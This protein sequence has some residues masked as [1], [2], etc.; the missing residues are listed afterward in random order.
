MGCD[1]SIRNGAELN[2]SVYWLQLCSILALSAI[3]PRASSQRELFCLVR[4]VC[5]YKGR[6]FVETGI[7]KI[8]EGFAVVPLQCRRIVLRDEEQHPHW[9]KIRVW[10]LP[11]G[12]LDRCDAERPY[13][14]LQVEKRKV[15][16]KNTCPA[17]QSVS[18]HSTHVEQRYCFF[19]QN[20][21]HTHTRTHIRLRCRPRT[22]FSPLTAIG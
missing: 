18:W 10:R 9:V 22:S 14:S 4:F 3:S 1:W 16:F 8:L 15:L 6:I 2:G 17:S 19:T 7:Y 12:Q 11:L 5:T 21:T 20:T 13:I